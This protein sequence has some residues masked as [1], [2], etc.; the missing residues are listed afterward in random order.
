MTISE[1][2]EIIAKVQKESLEKLLE[3]GKRLDE[4]GFF[5]YRDIKIY[6]GFLE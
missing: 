1:D 6:V 5:D 3:Q 2:K 4:R